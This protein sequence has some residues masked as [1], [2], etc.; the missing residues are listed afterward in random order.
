MQRKFDF[1]IAIEA[2]YVL[3]AHINSKEG[4]KILQ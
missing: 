4:L 1:W 2:L 3:V